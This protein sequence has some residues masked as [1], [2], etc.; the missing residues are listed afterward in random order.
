MFVCV[1][2]LLV[3]IINLLSRIGF[4][5]CPYAHVVHS[6]EESTVGT[7]DVLPVDVELILGHFSTFSYYGCV[8]A[9]DPF[10]W[11]VM[12]RFWAVALLI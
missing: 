11:C 6:S 1:F 9:V 12:Q 2:G 10:V 7:N 5:V 4:T 3:C 8:V